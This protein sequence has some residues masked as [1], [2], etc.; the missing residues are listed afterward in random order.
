[1]EDIE[2]FIARHVRRIILEQDDAPT[3]QTRGLGG[4][5]KKELRGLK[6]LA[7]SS[8]SELM[9]RLGVGGVSGEKPGDQ[10]VDLITQAVNNSS[11]MGD[12]YSDPEDIEDSYGRVGI[13][14]GMSGDA[15]KEMSVRDAA[16]FIK[17]T[18]RGARGAGILTTPEPIQ[19]ELLGNKILVYPSRS[20]YMW[21]MPIKQ[22]KPRKKPA[23]KLPPKATPAAKKSP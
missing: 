20:K 10:V 22:K 23:Q 2:K 16:I 1:M 11:E 8:P 19:V 15:A 12:A 6:A 3:P 21:G 14:V 18:V 4:G 13:S 7:D 17:H 5:L 9:S